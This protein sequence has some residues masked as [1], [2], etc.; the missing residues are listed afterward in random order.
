MKINPNLNTPI[1]TPPRAKE[2][3]PA[4]S[5]VLQ[6]V[7]KTVGVVSGLALTFNRMIVGGCAGGGAG[8]VKAT[9]LKDEQARVA[10]QV[11]LTANLAATGALAGGLG[12]SEL[13]LS[14]SEGALAGAATNAIIGNSDW[15]GSP[16]SFQQHVQGTAEQWVQESLSRLPETGDGMAGKFARG[17][18]GEVV[19]LGAGVYASAVRAP[20]T[21]RVGYEWGTRTTDQVAMLMT[22]RREE[23]RQ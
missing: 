9:G 18:V 6:A 19:G 11:A 7:G 14:P 3:E 5:V 8:I 10:F 16:Q 12:Y 2:K 20:E 22:S 13:A 23:A 4:D 15:N 21:F 1:A 17:V